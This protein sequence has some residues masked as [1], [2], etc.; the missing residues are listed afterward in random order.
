MLRIVQ[1]WTTIT[2][3]DQAETASVRRRDGAR[4][5]GADGLFDPLADFGR[6]GRRR[7][8]AEYLL[9]IQAWKMVRPAHHL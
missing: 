6:L 2:L 5:R 9:D 7:H 8:P 4:L 1:I 3:A